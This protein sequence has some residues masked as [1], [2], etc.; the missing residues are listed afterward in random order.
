MTCFRLLLWAATA[1]LVCIT[2]TS[3]AEPTPADRVAARALFEDARAAMKEG[4]YRAACPKLEESQH[5]DPGIG[6]LYNLAR[7]YEDQGRLA[8]AW[9]T[10]ADVA[11]AAHRAGQED[12]ATAARARA[13]ALEPRLPRL[14]VMLIGPDARALTLDGAPFAESLAGT[15]VPVDPGAHE[16]GADAPGKQHWAARV[17]A[18][19]EGA[20]SQLEVPLLEDAPQ[21]PAV[22]ETPPPVAPSPERPAAPAAPPQQPRKWQTTTALITG[23]AGVVGLAAGAVLGGLAMSKWSDAKGAG[24]AL[25]SAGQTNCPTSDAYSAWSTAHAEGIAST[26]ACI[27]GGVLAATGAV[28][29]FTGPRASVGVGARADGVVLVSGVLP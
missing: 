17:D 19:E 2:R 3:L 14:R 16:I 20:V 7:C 1:A 12:R 26:V 11:E 8:S 27:A 21:A 28:L 13:T 29:W 24:C 5:L 18:T 23:G 15:S 6:T 9:T 25:N 4:D 22:P 10:F